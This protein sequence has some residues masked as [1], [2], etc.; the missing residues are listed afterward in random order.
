MSEKDENYSSYNQPYPL[1]IHSILPANKLL[2][3]YRKVQ[4]NKKK[5]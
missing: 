4:R 5:L 1:N 3:I 2:R